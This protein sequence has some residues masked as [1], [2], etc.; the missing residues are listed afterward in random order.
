MAKK[1][2]LRPRLRV[3]N[4]T[5]EAKGA[6]YL[7]LVPDLWD[8][9]VFLEK[10][11]CAFQGAYFIWEDIRYMETRVVIIAIIVEDPESVTAVNHLLHEYAQYIIGRM[12][13]PYRAR[14]MNIISVVLDAPHD[15]VSTLSGKIGRLKG[16]SAK[17]VYSR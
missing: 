1:L 2:F 4:P 3:F 8:Y 7:K 6:I 13:L 9:C 5:L 12:G 17:T 16:V 10:S 11:M 14:N 15:E